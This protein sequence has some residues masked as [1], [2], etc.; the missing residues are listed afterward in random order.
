MCTTSS[1]YPCDQWL[2]CENIIDRDFKKRNAVKK[3]EN[4]NKNIR[5]IITC[6][7]ENNLISKKKCKNQ[8]SLTSILE[9]FDAVVN[10]GAT[11]LSVTL[12]VTGVGLVV[13]PISA[14][15]A[16]AFLIK[17]IHTM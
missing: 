4:S 1:L 3:F 2:V 6:F 11:K 5:E 14:G 15:V 17:E 10:I 12:P 9:S 13:V 8:K 16:C 7:K